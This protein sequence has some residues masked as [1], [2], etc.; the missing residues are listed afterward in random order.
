MESSDF[1]VPLDLPQP[2]F[3]CEECMKNSDF[4]VILDLPLPGRN[5]LSE[6]YIV[7]FVFDF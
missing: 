7:S 3:I 4:T 6:H 2:G 5:L 1:A